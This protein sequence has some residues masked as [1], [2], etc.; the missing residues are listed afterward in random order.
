MALQTLTTVNLFYFIMCEDLHKYK[1]IEIA[2]GWRPNHEWLHTTLEVRRPHCM[3]L[4]VWWD[5][6]WTFFWA[7]TISWSRILACVWSG[8]HNQFSPS[9]F[10]IYHSQDNLL[11]ISC[12]LVL[13]T[14]LNTILSV[15]Y[16]LELHNDIPIKCLYHNLPTN[17][18]LIVWT[19]YHINNFSKYKFTSTIERYN[20][21]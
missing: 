3:I 20:T 2:L 21:V 11:F 7:L 5:G 16:F 6:L 17:V 4:E 10:Q 19:L 1:F 14:T 8:P 18:K 12:F 9:L 15:T 13:S